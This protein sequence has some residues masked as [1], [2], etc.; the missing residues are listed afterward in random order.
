MRVGRYKIAGLPR[1]S[2]QPIAISPED[3]GTSTS[4]ASGRGSHSGSSNHPSSSSSSGDEADV[5]PGAPELTIYDL[6]ANPGEHTK[7]DTSANARFYLSRP[8][9]TG[10]KQFHDNWRNLHGPTEE[11]TSGDGVEDDGEEIMELTAR[12]MVA[13]AVYIKEVRLIAIF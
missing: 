2:I 3:A 4:T 12:E 7:L 8:A 11:T 10:S 9:A 1:L 6:G 5:D 13:V